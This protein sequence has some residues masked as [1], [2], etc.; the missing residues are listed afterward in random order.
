[1]FRA[2]ALTAAFLLAA[3]SDPTHP[4]DSTRTPAGTAPNARYVGISVFHVKGKTVQAGFDSYDASG[5]V[6]T[7]AYVV[8]DLGLSGSDAAAYVSVSRYDYCTG[9]YLYA[10]GST[11]QINLQVDN[12][13][14][15]S[16]LTA[17]I[18]VYDY[19]NDV[20]FNLA[21]NLAWTATGPASTYSD[22]STFRGPGYKNVSSFRGTFRPAEATG[23]ISD[24]TTNF[25][26]NA[27]YWAEIDKIKSG[28]V[29]IS[30]S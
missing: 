23:S 26:P 14:D 2:L 16:S 25:A 19:Y 28:S 17:T 18:P 7:S 12:K 6:E 20:S 21:V 27:S 22:H 5:C 10:D 30:R 8:G 15:A 1:M 29:S 9:A 11:T 13:L 4:P 3:C 24:G